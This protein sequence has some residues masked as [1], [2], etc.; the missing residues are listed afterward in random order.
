MS[1]FSIH[2]IESAPDAAKDTLKIAKQK[3]RYVPNLLGELAASPAAARAY[4][5]L[6]ELLAETAFTP[7]EQNIILTAASVANDCAYCVA[8]HSAALMTAGLPGPEIEAIRRGDA[9]PDPM[10]ET[11]RRFTTV[12]VRTHGHPPE[13]EVEQFLDAG[14]DRDHIFE[15]LIGVAMNTLSNYTDHIAGTPL[16]DKL[17]HFA[18]G[19][20]GK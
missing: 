11:L 19:P 1:N 12:L 2:T 7:V 20:V 10:L 6:H 3:F 9:L 18:W 8:T 17:Q 14:Y 4:M 13:D 15:V 5:A 16:D